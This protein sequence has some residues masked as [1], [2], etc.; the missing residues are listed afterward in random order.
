MSVSLTGV[1]SG[2]TKVGLTDRSAPSWTTNLLDLYVKTIDVFSGYQN[3]L[4]YNVGNEVV[5]A[6]NGTGAAAF[7]KGAARDV[8]AYLYVGRSPL[9][10]QVL[11]SHYFQ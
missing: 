8:K 11:M 1:T 5:I 6:A 3:V 7:V 4:G 10:R 9:L 2:R